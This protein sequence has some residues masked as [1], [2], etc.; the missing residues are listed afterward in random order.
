MEDCSGPTPSCD[1]LGNQE[2]ES[3]VRDGGSPRVRAKEAQLLW[4][5]W[6]G[7]EAEATAWKEA[8]DSLDRASRP[9]LPTVQVVK[10]GS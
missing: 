9:S 5:S 4:N 1:F 7:T 3:L 6:F 2:E 10:T 8:S